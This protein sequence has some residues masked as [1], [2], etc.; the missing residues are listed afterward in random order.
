MFQILCAGGCGE[1]PAAILIFIRNV[2]QLCR[3]FI[4]LIMLVIGIIKI[5]K[6]RKGGKN[7]EKRKKA[8]RLIIISLVV[9]LV[10]TL[11][12]VGYNSYI[13]NRHYDDTVHCWC[14]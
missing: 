5:V 9:F 12:Q 4:P 6:Y 1:E 7:K 2:L 8:I 10:L 3:I 11:V 14:K 13:F